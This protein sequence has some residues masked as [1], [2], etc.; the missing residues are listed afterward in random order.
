MFV[1]WR[2]LVVACLLWCE[3][4]ALLVFFGFES[5]SSQPG[6]S[7]L[8]EFVTLPRSKAQTPIFRRDFVRVESRT[9]LVTVTPTN[10]RPFNEVLSAYVGV[11]F[12]VFC[13][14]RQGRSEA[15]VVY[16]LVVSR[17]VGTRRVSEAVSVVHGKKGVLQRQ[18]IERSGSR[19]VCVINFVL[20]SA[21]S[22]L[23]VFYHHT[24]NT[25][26]KADEFRSYAE[27]A[28]RTLKKFQATASNSNTMVR[29]LYSPTIVLL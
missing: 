13:D 25:I 12:A 5:H 14:R 20:C 24:C 4:F 29:P 23:F 21:N 7:N 17:V 3:V 6:N 15:G 16:C 8:G 28:T 18:P 9:P 10:Q 22:A 2:L 26:T 19:S 11:Y 27:D 1:V